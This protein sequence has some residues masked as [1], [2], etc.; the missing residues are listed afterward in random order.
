MTSYAPN[1]WSTKLPP[2]M[3]NSPFSVK[4]ITRKA[5]MFTWMANRVNYSGL[6]IFT[7]YDRSAGEHVITFEYKPQS[8][9]G[10]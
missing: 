3:N 9:F 4:Y 7:S 5:G 8:Y 2:P 1:K 10:S 6:T